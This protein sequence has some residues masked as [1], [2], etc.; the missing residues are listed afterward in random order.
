MRILLLIAPLVLT[1]AARYG[2][3]QDPIQEHLI[4]PEVIMQNQA[5]LQLSA[6]QRDQIRDRVTAAQAE[7]TGLHWD[8]QSEMEVMAKLLSD[9]STDEAAVLSQL[10]N[11]LSLEAN[12]KR[13]QIGMLVGIR[14]VLTPD[15]YETA[16]GLSRQAR[17]SKTS[18]PTPPRPPG[19]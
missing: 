5:R 2:Q 19:D 3:A 4:P 6:E 8:L 18:P 7:F 10:E 16:R 14:R 12:V 13:A 1:V 15:Q 11:I 17:K 9:L